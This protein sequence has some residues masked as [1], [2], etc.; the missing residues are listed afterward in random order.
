VEERS[1]EW[2]A[3]CRVA[4]DANR[5]RIDLG[6][7]V[8]RSAFGAWQDGLEREVSVERLARAGVDVANRGADLGIAVG[9]EIFHQK[10]NETAVTLEERK[11]LHG[12]IVRRRD[13]WR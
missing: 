6:R 1:A 13:D 12:A 4:D 9:A 8:D 3:P 5:R 11:D 2:E 10:V 7:D